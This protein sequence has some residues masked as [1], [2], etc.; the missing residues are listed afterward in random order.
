M[1]MVLER[2]PVVEH[3]TEGINL[4][5]GRHRRYLKSLLLTAEVAPAVTSASRAL[6]YALSFEDIGFVSTK[7]RLLIQRQ[8][9]TRFI[10][11]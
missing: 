3:A 8:K 1:Y 11:S 10:E 5:V 6:K 2:C 9:T 7:W 4:N